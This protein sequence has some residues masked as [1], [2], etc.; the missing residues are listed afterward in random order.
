MFSGEFSGLFFLVIVLGDGLFCCFW[1][2]WQG[3]DE[4]VEDGVVGTF[5]ILIVYLAHLLL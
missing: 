3:E 1:L 4:F 5:D 2:F